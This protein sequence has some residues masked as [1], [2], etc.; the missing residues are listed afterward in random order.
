M[1]EDT[2][3]SLRNTRASFAFR[4]F[5]HIFAL[6]FLLYMIHSLTSL[7][8]IFALM[9]FASHCN[10]IS[11]CFDVPVLT[12]GYV[13]VSFFFVLSGFVIS[14]SYDERFRLRAVSAKEFWVARIA[15]IYP[16]H[17][18]MLLVA[19][20]LGTCTLANGFFY[21]VRHFVANL[22]LCQ[23]YIPDSDYYFSFNSPS[24]S[25]CCEQLF[26]LC[27]PFIVPLLRH[28]RRLCM[29]FAVC[30]VIVVVGM[31][32]TPE[33]LD[34]GIW[35][36]NPLTRFPDFLLGM[37]V[38]VCYR[39]CTSF[40]CNHRWGTCMELFAILLF[41]LFYVIAP[42]ISQVY[43][44]SCFYW[45]PIAGVIFVFSLQKGFFS[46]LLSCRLLVLGGEISFGF[47]MIHHLLI[48]VYLETER[49]LPFTIP[50]YVVVLLLLAMTLLLS[51]ISYCYFERPMNRLVKASLKEKTQN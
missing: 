43:R 46:R 42:D 5:V 40:T 51:A 7:R 13:G 32:L 2:L 30:A 29:V 47:Y 26:Y 10:M 16:L 9:V 25:L 50:P 31:G 23:A 20:A 48:R 12:E 24:W 15:R 41:G 49:F 19:A 18:L 27:F 39:R 21:W 45:I 17:V 1:F 33:D 22:F 28:P 4:S 38:Y 35:Y 3:H 6:S 37:I 8:L 36:V 44:Y 11:V 34:K 14:Y